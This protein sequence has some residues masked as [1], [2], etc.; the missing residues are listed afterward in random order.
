MNFDRDYLVPLPNL[1]LSGAKLMMAEY[2]DAARLSRM[3]WGALKTPEFEH[4][5]SLWTEA[6]ND[7]FKDPPGAFWT[8]HSE[9]NWMPTWT[10]ALHYSKE[11]RDR[12]GWSI[13]PSE[14]YVRSS[15]NIVEEMQ[16][17]VAL[18]ASKA[19]SL[20]V[21][22][23]ERVLRD[24]QHHLKERRSSPN[25]VEDQIDSLKMFATRQELVEGKEELTTARQTAAK[26]D[27]DDELSDIGDIADHIEDLP[28]DSVHMHI[29]DE[30]PIEDEIIPLPASLASAEEHAI[31]GAAEIESE[32]SDLE[33]YKPPRPGLV[34]AV[35][36]KR[37]FRRLHRWKRAGAC[38]K[39]P[40]LDYKTYELVPGN[41]IN[42][43][44]FDDYCHVCWRNGAS[45]FEGKEEEN[46][47]PLTD[48]DS[49]SDSSVSSEEPSEGES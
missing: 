16:R 11:D 34:V 25:D 2:A 41:N 32:L 46:G 13:E 20:D 44:V 33:E 5:T 36:G 3:L 29:A 1:S 17:Q 49:S 4:D 10:A 15:R 27:Q 21:A 38:N 7:L 18:R 43:A 42:Q 22:D 19:N 26:V 9:R 8:E 37:K 47:Q 45:P 30:V 14:E 12:L 39:K 40:G 23:E 48:D 6:T 31:Q 35:L 28:D 24:L